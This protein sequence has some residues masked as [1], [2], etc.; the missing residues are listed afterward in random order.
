MIYKSILIVCLVFIL[1]GCF[2]VSSGTQ[3]K[4]DNLTQVEYTQIKKDVQNIATTFKPPFDC[5][6][7]EKYWKANREKGQLICMGDPIGDIFTDM[8]KKVIRIDYSGTY[9][10]WIP[11]KEII[12]DEHKKIQKLFLELAKKYKKRYPKSVI[13]VIFRHHDLAKDGRKLF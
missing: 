4:I 8:T 2:R 7:D 5:Q 1:N 6:Y 3:I 9:A 13:E 11:K 10:F 12:T